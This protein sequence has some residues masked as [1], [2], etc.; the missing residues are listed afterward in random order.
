MWRSFHPLVAAIILAMPFPLVCQTGTAVRITIRG[1]ALLVAAE[2]S[3]TAQESLALGGSFFTH[4]FVSGLRGAAD[5]DGDQ[6]V[7]LAEIRTY[8]THATKTATGSPM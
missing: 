7:S 5:L 3:E 2:S 8:T 6:R 4:F 1:T